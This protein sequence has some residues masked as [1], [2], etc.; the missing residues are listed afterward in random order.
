MK[1][2]TFLIIVGVLSIIGGAFAFFNPLAATLTAEQLVA[3]LFLLVGILQLVAVWK[4]RAFIST[5]WLGIG[6][7][8]SLLIGGFLLFNPLQ[9]AVTLT[10]MVAALLLVSGVSQVV[11]ALA[12]RGTP[13]FLAILL[14]GLLSL[15]LA[16]LIFAD[17]PASATS[18]LG[19]FLAIE[20][21]SN[22]VSTL[23][24]AN[25]F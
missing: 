13:Y 15:V 24:V 11:F 18:I 7:I 5:L 22:G 23:L 9:G 20:L 19:I 17:F 3:W 1:N 16:V 21:I 4:Y 25:K 12:W 8:L 6:A 2:K 10:A 14:S